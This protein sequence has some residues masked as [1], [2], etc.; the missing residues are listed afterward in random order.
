M[1]MHVIFDQ[2]VFG[3]WNNVFSYFILHF[4]FEY[5]VFQFDFME[6]IFRI[7]WWIETFKKVNILLHYKCFYCHFWSI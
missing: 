5:I 6:S 1:S 3:E 2:W 7:F 4:L